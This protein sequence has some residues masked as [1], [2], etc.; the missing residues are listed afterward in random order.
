VL[1]PRWGRAES[2]DVIREIHMEIQV[3][4]RS[5]PQ[6]SGHRITSD[7]GWALTAHRWPGVGRMP[8]GAF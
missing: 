6:T 5:W 7:L 3:C 8:G 4:P 1:F 2:E